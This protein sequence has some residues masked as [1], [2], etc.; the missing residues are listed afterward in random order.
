MNTHI[1]PS[2]DRQ[3]IK[4]PIAQQYH[5]DFLSPVECSVIFD[6]KLQTRC[7][8]LLPSALMSHAYNPQTIKYILCFINVCFNERAHTS[9]TL[10]IPNRCKMCACIYATLCIF[11]EYSIEASIQ[12]PHKTL[13][14]LFCAVSSVLLL[15]IHSMCSQLFFI[16]VWLPLFLTFDGVFSVCVCVSVWIK[17]LSDWVEMRHTTCRLRW[18]QYHSTDRIQFQHIITTQHTNT[19]QSIWFT[20]KNDFILNLCYV[21]IIHIFINIYLIGVIAE[22]CLRVWLRMSESLLW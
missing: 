22:N 18:T 5:A 7:A 20:M 17:C 8:H 3:M 12:S 4:S 9:Q 13:Y 6:G 11:N 10:S 21:S 14:A 19:K 16:I 2:H 15:S 1:N